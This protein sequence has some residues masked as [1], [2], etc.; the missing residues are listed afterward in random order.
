MED[1]VKDDGPIKIDGNIN[2]S[3]GALAIIFGSLIIITAIIC[4]TVMAVNGVFS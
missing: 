1:N 3:D 4:A 2:A